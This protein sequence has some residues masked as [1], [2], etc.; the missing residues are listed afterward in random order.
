MDRQTAEQSV[1]Q[2]LDQFYGFALKRTA[3]T[4]DAED[5]A[6]DI[7]LKCFA[8]LLKQ[9]PENANAFMWRIAHNIL[10]NYY[11]GKARAGIGI[12]IADIAE[13][14]PSSE[15]VSETV[16]NQDAV[17]R[18][19]TRIAYLSALQR[20]IVV[21]H[22]Y[23]GKKLHEIAALLRI[24]PG[25]VK[26][27]LFEARTELKKGMDFM[28]QIDNLNFNPI[29]F[30]IMGFSGS[31]GT[32][33][34]LNNILRCTLTQNIAYCVYR[35]AKTINE[36]ADCLG[37]SP[38][39]VESEMDFLE[40]HGFLVK[41]GKKYLTNFLI[42]EPNEAVETVILP[43]QEE[44]YGTAARLIANDLYDE[45]FTSPLLESADLFYPDGDKNFLAWGLL[46]YILS[47]SEIDI[48]QPVSFEEAATARP[49]G[50]K[51]IAYAGFSRDDGPVQKYFDS[52]L[53]WNGPMWNADES[54][55]L[56][57]INSEWSD[58]ITG[59][60]YQSEAMR[61]IK[62]LKRF[63][64]GETLPQDDLV[65]LAQNGYIKGAAGH[66]ELAVVHLKTRE[67]A[68]QFLALGSRIKQKHIDALRPL[69]ER[70]TNSVLNNTPPQVRKMQA[71]GLSFLFQS[72]GWFLL[73]CVNE[74]LINGKLRLPTAAQRQSLST[75][76]LPNVSK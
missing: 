35:E 65:Y 24:P 34:G 33:G 55:L 58:R 30:S 73:H 46:L 60:N 29:S 64:S 74:L 20:R 61:A 3:T 43:L 51:N 40:E 19:R 18:L 31:V 17:K 45:L 66:F 42:D 5:L 70:F 39:Y 7:A 15:D 2:C 26:W 9:S 32:M 4:Q 1:R 47:Q 57:Q 27:H 67:C 50:G 44:M 41:T 63:T 69:M 28:N 38:V 59:P 75:V 13:S 62:L 52:M 25:T 21:L 10:A 71:F 68:E 23:E 53:Q 14:L 16:V 37:V 8:G 54:L 49:D 6:Q 36:I 48:K 76:L 12:S 72:D 56:W 11:R 22:Y